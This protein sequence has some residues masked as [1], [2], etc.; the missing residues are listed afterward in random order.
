MPI[1]SR[2]GWRSALLRHPVHGGEVA[3]DRPVVPDIPRVEI[4]RRTLDRLTG[5][6]SLSTL[7]RCEQQHVC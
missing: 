4:G 2:A 7:S 3:I 6:W 5:L 1:G